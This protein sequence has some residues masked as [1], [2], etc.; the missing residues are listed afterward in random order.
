MSVSYMFILP[1]VIQDYDPGLL[2][3]TKPL[4]KILLEDIMKPWKILVIL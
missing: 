2:S 3:F 1:C 4:G